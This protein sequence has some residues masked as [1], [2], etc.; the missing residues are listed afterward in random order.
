M[1]LAVVAQNSNSTSY[2][3]LH[4]KAR[5]FIFWRRLGQNHP[6]FLI[7]QSVHYL[8]SLNIPRDL[9]NASIQHETIFLCQLLLSLAGVRKNSVF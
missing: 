1:E 3:E 7:D 2:S 8:R 4:T 9:P 6:I 5:H